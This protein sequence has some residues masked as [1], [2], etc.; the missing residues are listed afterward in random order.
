MASQDAGDFELTI[1]PIGPSG[2]PETESAITVSE[3]TGLTDWTLDK[4][5]SFNEGPGGRAFG[6]NH[7]RSGN[8]VTFTINVRDTSPDLGAIHE[9]SRNEQEVAIRAQVAKNEETYEV[10]QEIGLG[11]NRCIILPGSRSHGDG[12]AADVS[13][14]I[15]GI[16]PV[17]ITKDS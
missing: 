11:A 2:E 9:L 7:Q 14:D 10:G 4:D 1:T 13:F 5:P 16:D 8:K 17:V 6:F 12:E 15:L 3:F